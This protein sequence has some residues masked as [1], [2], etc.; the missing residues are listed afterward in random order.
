ML[1]LF[2]L[3][4]SHYNAPLLEKKM[5]VYSDV[6]GSIIASILFKDNSKFKNH[7]CSGCCFFWSVQHHLSYSWKLHSSI[8][9]SIILVKVML[10]VAINTWHNFNA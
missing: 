9:C 6:S 2:G 7:C 1:C 10:T 8:L 3:W 4:L 5:H